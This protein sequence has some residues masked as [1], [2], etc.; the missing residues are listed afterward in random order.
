MAGLCSFKVISS[1]LRTLDYNYNEYE[2]QKVVL[3]L[4]LPYHYLLH[5]FENMCRTS[6]NLVENAKQKNYITQNYYA[7]N[8]NKQ[9]LACEKVEITLTQLHPHKKREKKIL[10]PLRVKVKRIN[11]DTGQAKSRVKLK[12]R[13]T[14]GITLSES[15]EGILIYSKTFVMVNYLN[16]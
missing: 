5:S 15:V 11:S 12:L 14:F 8:K 7:D 3:L 2:N 9:T 1:K 13:R 16:F 6:N 4:S 10:H